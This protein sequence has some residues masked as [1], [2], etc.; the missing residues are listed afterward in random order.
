M[1]AYYE[2]DEI[3]IID[4]DYVEGIGSFCT[5]RKS[6]GTIGYAPTNEVY[7]Y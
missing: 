5:Y 4:Y 7:I 6:D 3:E 1:N 2:N